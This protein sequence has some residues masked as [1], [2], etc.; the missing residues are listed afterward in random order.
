MDGD[1]LT[2]SL[3]PSNQPAHGSVSFDNGTFTYTPSA[4]AN[5][6]DLFVIDIDDGHGGTIQQAVSVTINA[7]NDAPTIVGGTA[8]LPAID[9]DLPS[10]AGY[11]VSSVL[12]S[13]F[14]DAA[15]AQASVDN[16]TGSTADTFLGIAITGNGSSAGTGQWQYYDGAN[17]I[18]IGA[19]SASSALLLEAGTMIRF[20]PAQDF[21][22]SATPVPAL[23]VHLIESGYGVFADGDLADLST[24]GTTGGASHVSAGT[25]AVSETIN[26]VD[27]APTATITP[28]GGGFQT[29]EQIALDLKHTISVGD[30]DSGPGTVTVTLSVDYGLIYVTAGTSGVT[31]ITGDNS[32]S[33][34]ITGTIGAIQS[35]LDSDASSLVQYTPNTNT[36][37]AS[38]TISLAIDDGGNSGSGGPLSADASASVSIFPVNDAPAGIDHGLPVTIGTPRVLGPSVFTFTDAELNGLLSVTINTLPTAGTIVFD[39]DG[40]GGNP[41]VPI[42]AGDTFTA[43]QVNGARLLYVPGPGASGNNYDSFTYSVRDNGGT[44]H[45]GLDT[46]ASPNTITVNINTTNSAPTEMGLSGDNAVYTEESAPVPLDVGRDA[47]ISDPDSADFD[48]GTLNVSIIVNHHADQDLLDFDQSGSVQIVGADV[49]VDGVTI[50]TL[51]AAGGSGNIA[52]TFNALATPDLVTTLI[53][54]LTYANSDTVSP[55]GDQRIVE[56]RLSDGDGGTL[57]VDSTIEVRGVNDAPTLGAT[58]LTPTF[59]EGDAAVVLFQDAAGG[60][61]ESDQSFDRLVFTVSN[62]SGGANERIHL[63]GSTI[64]LTDGASLTSADHGLAV[65][66]TV[67]GGTATVTVDGALAPS[68]FATLIDSIAYEHAG[69]DPMAGDRVITLT[70]ARDDGGTDNGG[71]D[72]VDLSISATVTVVPVDDL[73]VVHPDA[74]ATDEASLLHGSVFANNGSGADV[75][76]DS[77]LSVAA[78]NGS[79]TNVG[80][81]I[82]LASGARLTLNADGSFDYDPHH[83]FDATP[84]AGSGASNTPAHDSFTYTLLNGGTATVSVTI[85]GLDSNDLLLG[86]AGNDSL[87]GGVG[88]DAYIVNQPGDVVTELVGQGNDTVYTTGSYALAAGSEVE[89]L[90]VYDRTTTNPL[91]LT[92]NGFANVIYGNNGSDAL[93][94]GAGADTM[95][96]LGGDDFFI[97]D[98]AGDQVIEFA[99]QGNDTV[100]TTVSYTLTAGSE[101]ETLT[102]Y[103]RTTTNA[104][105]LTGNSFN[106]VIFGNNGADALIGGG[107]NDTMYGLGGNDGYIVDSASDQAIEFAGQGNDTVYTTVSY[108]LTA[109]SE[110]ETLTAYDRASTNALTLTG[111]AFDNV[112]FGNNGADALIGGGGNDTM[113]GLGGNDGYIVDSASDQVIEFA[114]QGNDTVYT[115]VSYTLTAGSEIETLTAYDRTATN[116]LVLP[117]TPWTM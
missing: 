18:D 112:I 105:T 3:D 62:V 76:P 57:F 80:A 50:G 54:A 15:D 27:D 8:A 83:A 5:G 97:V 34:T 39:A 77:P 106:N 16:P 21:N 73:P 7:V 25:V 86:T 10:A 113:Y 92:G 93:I 33:V 42:H 56:Y 101:I 64:A 43:L 35:L 110:I 88:N 95:Y 84:A 51:T 70:S 20:N 117:A 85:A 71:I 2:Y 49:D 46:D 17:W 102:V 104:L 68:A 108:T 52:I 31:S 87:A 69:D 47:V 74:V 1:T 22:T 107:G 79:S 23:D 96:G 38:A 109:G 44:L 103:D 91:V 6:A 116:A 82:V 40:P 65:T 36:P 114:G 61:I 26:A 32:A 12:A 9:E 100:Y 11:S 55:S 37:P 67:S 19:V 98:N 14:S 111:N 60:T 115:S 28:P 94:G 90:T 78:V 66:V 99:G 48:G 72:T 75:D 63:D 24:G 58:G 30:V 89:T 41:A 45:G 59:T 53:H 4:D 13:H 81:P 29:D